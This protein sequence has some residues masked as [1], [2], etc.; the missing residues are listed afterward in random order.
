MTNEQKKPDGPV[1][2]GPTTL[3][4]KRARLMRGDNEVVGVL[5]SNDHQVNSKNMI[6][7]FND[8]NGKTCISPVTSD[9]LENINDA[10][11]DY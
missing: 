7:K 2:H 4:G 6:F 11:M 5:L 8:A 1:I 9:E 3:H 10:L